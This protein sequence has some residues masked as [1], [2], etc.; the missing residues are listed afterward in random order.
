MAAENGIYRN[1]PIEIDGVY[2]IS[3]RQ[4]LD[5]LLLGV[6]PRQPRLVYEVDGNIIT[7]ATE[8]ALHRKMTTEVHSIGDI[9]SSPADFYTNLDELHRNVTSINP[10]TTTTSTSTP[11]AS[12]KIE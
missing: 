4:S 5:I 6:L 2:S 11:T 12:G 1:T 9:S 3:F 10:S 7:I 8:D